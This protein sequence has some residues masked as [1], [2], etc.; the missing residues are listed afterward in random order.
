MFDVLINPDATCTWGFL[1]DNEQAT[2]ATHNLAVGGALL[3]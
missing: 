1:V 2:L 3:Q